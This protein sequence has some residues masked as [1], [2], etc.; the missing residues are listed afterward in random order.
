[1]GKEVTVGVGDGVG[2]GVGVRVGTAVGVAVW[3][4]VG[5]AVDG[6]VVAGVAGQPA[7]AINPASRTAINGNRG[8]IVRA[9]PA[10]G[11]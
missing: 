7:R 8:F 10:F 2:D 1:M 5:D 9:T 3:T 11:D 4:A 6:R